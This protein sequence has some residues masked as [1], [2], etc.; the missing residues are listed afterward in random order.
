MKYLITEDRM[1]DTIKEFLKKMFPQVVSVSFGVKPVM[2]ASRNNEIIQRKVI[3][4]TMDPHNILTGGDEVM[5]DVVAKLKNNIKEGL[6]VMFGLNLKE[7]GSKW[8]VRIYVLK[9]VEV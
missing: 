3:E 6:D 7:Y 4:I 2:L 1:R 5:Y 8:E 9:K